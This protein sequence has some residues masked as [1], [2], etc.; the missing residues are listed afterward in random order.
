MTSLFVILIIAGIVL[1]ALGLFI[2]AAKFLI[3]VGI[4]IAVIAAIAWLLR[5]ISGRRSA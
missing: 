3:W 1:L 5:Y 2:E 4:V